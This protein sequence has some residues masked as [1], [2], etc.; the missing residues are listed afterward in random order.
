MG[1]TGKS[2]SIYKA[3]FLKTSVIS[4][5]DIGDTVPDSAFSGKTWKELRPDS[6][7]SNINM[8]IEP[9][10]SAQYGTKNKMECTQ[11]GFYQFSGRIDKY[12]SSAFESNFIDL[13]KSGLGT[14]VIGTVSTTISTVVDDA[15]FTCPTGL[16]IA[17]DS[18]LI[19]GQI[20]VVDSVSVSTTDTV[21]LKYKVY[22]MTSS[23]A[24]VSAAYYNP[25]NL[26]D[27]NY[28]HFLFVTD[29]G[30]YLA[31]WVKPSVS[32]T[33]EVNNKML[34]SFNLTGDFVDKTT[35]TPTLN[36][37]DTTTC[38][39][40]TTNLKAVFLCSESKNTTHT[41]TN[42]TLERAQTRIPMQGAGAGNGYGGTFQEQFNLTCELKTSGTDSILK[43][44]FDAETSFKFLAFAKDGAYGIESGACVFHN[45]NGANIEDGQYR[46]ILLFGLNQIEATDPKIFL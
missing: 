20:T 26:E 35:A 5:Y 44:I 33:T 37:A 43:T 30:N 10:K 29:D 21:T 6:D 31:T 14:K 4:G 40:S 36:T 11:K 24:V 27:D 18:L 19:N 7:F 41:N 16:I 9:L 3:Y 38:I 8:V 15:N 17:G 23:M 42:I 46:P 39:A 45:F 12:H 34:I 22:G 28:F 32:F 25:V 1:V 2:A 13:L